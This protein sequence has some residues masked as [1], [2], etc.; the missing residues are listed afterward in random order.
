MFSWNE[1]SVSKD[2]LVMVAT[3]IIATLVLVLIEQGHIGRLISYLPNL[4][5]RRLHIADQE[6][7]ELLD[8]DVREV[9]ERVNA[10]TTS[11]L[12]EQNLVLQNVSKYYGSFLAVN[13][14]SIEIKQ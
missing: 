2:L 13:Q 1:N 10:M 5:R 3:S 11:E 4:R 14:V 7:D 12:Q 9:K 8:D 6:S